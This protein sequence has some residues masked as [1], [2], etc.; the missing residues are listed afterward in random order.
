MDL[1]S[2][3]G[4]LGNMQEMMQQSKA[5]LEEMMV[6]VESNGIQIECT[7]S[8]KVKNISIA[9]SLMDE[10]DKEQLE[11]LLIA[12]LNKA[13]E[14]ADAKAQEEAQKVQQSLF[15]GGLPGF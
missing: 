4:Q 14:Q 10:G 7:A 13:M 8:K 12:A 9:Q 3:M 11:D 1:S 15:P 5:R 6:S 2:M